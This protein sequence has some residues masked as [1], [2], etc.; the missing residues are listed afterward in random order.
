MRLLRALFVIAALALAGAAGEGTPDEEISAGQAVGYALISALA[1]ADD[2]LDRAY[3]WREVGSRLGGPISWHLAAPDHAGRDAITKRTGWV[4]GTYE[5]AGVA[6]CGGDTVRQMSF[7]LDGAQDVVMAQIRKSFEESGVVLSP[8][9]Q[10]QLMSLA[11][12]SPGL[13]RMNETCT[14]PGSAMMRHCWTSVQL[15]LRAEDEDA[16]G[17][18]CRAP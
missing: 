11:N 9:G 13:L 3:A 18:E 12:F 8:H 2:P 6:A 7:R 17:L 14:R 1:P 5:S 4:Q 15:A 10:D 16:L